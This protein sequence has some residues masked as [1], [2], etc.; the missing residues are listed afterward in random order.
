MVNQRWLKTYLNILLWMFLILVSMSQF[1]CPRSLSQ[2]ELNLLLL[3]CMKAVIQLFMHGG[4]SQMDLLDPK[5]VLT[6]NH[7]QS[8]YDEVIADLTGPEQAGTI[9]R[10]PFQ[11]QPHGESGI[12]VSELLPRLAEVVDDITVIR[13]MHSVLTAIETSH[14]PVFQ[15][16]V[17]ACA[18]VVFGK[19]TG[20]ADQR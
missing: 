14:N 3:Q 1:I 11:F 8:Y 13:S 18:V 20:C 4:P 2:M 17:S 10:S 19:H 15:A 7:G 5:P 12:E 9:F 6:K 16:E